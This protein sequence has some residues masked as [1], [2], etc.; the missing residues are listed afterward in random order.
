MVEVF[1]PPGN[2]IS[3]SSS[4]VTFWN[5]NLL[6]LLCIS[7]ISSDIFNF[8]KF[9]AYSN[10]CKSIVSPSAKHDKLSDSICS[11]SDIVIFPSLFLSYWFNKNF[12][13]VSLAN[14]TSW[15]L[16]SSDV[17][18]RVCASSFIVCA[19]CVCCSSFSSF[20]STFVCTFS[21]CS[22]SVFC[23]SLFCVF[24]FCCS[25]LFILFW[26]VICVST[27]SVVGNITFDKNIN[28]TIIATIF[29]IFI[30]IPLLSL[31]Y[32]FYT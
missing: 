4:F 18:F 9:F 5:T 31:F 20:C 19:F 1:I 24:A 7:C 21:C 16:F 30:C 23:S 8:F 28:T 29:L 26:F 27:A 17:V 3:N 11:M 10:P 13:K 22:S 15:S 25:S 2:L 32:I 14:C 12:F 6:L